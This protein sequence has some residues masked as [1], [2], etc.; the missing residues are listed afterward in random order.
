MKT[1]Q[2]VD[3]GERE[4]AYIGASLALYITPGRLYT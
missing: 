4:N 1:K 2:T 3:E